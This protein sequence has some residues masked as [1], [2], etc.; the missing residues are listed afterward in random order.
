MNEKKSNL[1]KLLNSRK[2]RAEKFTSDEFIQRVKEDINNYEAKMPSINDI[3]GVNSSKQLQTALNYRYNYIIPMIFTNTEAAKA[4]LF[5]RLPDLIIKGRGKKDE[6]KAELIEAIYEYLKDKLDL[7]SFAWQAA[8]WFVLS[9]FTSATIGF[10]SKSEKNEVYDENGEP[11][12]DKETGEI[13]Y[14]EKFIEDDPT[15]EVDNPLKTFFAPDSEFDVDAKK[16]PYKIWWSALDVNEIKAKYGKDVEANYQEEFAT[17]KE[18]DDI[19]KDCNRVKTYFYCGIVPEEYKKDV[20]N[21]QANKIYYIIFTPQEILYT[22]EKKRKNFKICRWFANPTD[23]FGYGYGKIGAPF[24]KEK[25]VRVGQRIRF[26]DIAA[27][28]KYTIKND[29]KNKI[30]ID[31]LKDPRENLVLTYETDPPGLLQPGNLG[32]IV[33]EAERAADSDAQAAFGLLDLT[34][35]AQETSTVESATGQTIFAEASQRRIKHAKRIF[36]KFYRAC[37]IELF[38]QCQDNWTSDKIL[39]LTDEDGNSEDVIV[40]ADDLKDIDFDRDIEINAESVSVNKDVVRQQMIE[41]YDKVKDDPLIDRKVIFRDMLRKGFEINDPD[42]YFKQSEIAPGTTL[43][44][45]Q[46]G[47]QFTIDESGELLPAQQ[48][49]GTALSSPE[50]PINP[51]APSPKPAT[52]SQAG[53]SGAISGKVF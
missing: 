1:L 23:F 5:D 8:H 33:T 24:Q 52:P 21:W 42:H 7:D 14:E 51:Q 17:G 34:S 2:D 9:G 13:V 48:N 50:M 10:N 15:I 39:K 28:P 40:N 20:K 18:D 35:G 25:S 41:L 49:A 45:P 27:Y 6:A 43:V 47:E 44:N 38:K 16:V 31:S 46:T 32:G 26:A 29:G 22:E 53:M 36:M 4:S 30:D 11:L 37:V 3:L 12:I 19:K